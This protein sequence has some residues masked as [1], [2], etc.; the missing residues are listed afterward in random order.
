MVDKLTALV[1]KPEEAQ[2]NTR[3]ENPVIAKKA[4]NDL[5]KIKELQELKAEWAQALDLGGIKESGVP[6]G[7]TPEETQ[8]EVAAKNKNTGPVKAKVRKVQ[9]KEP[10]E[11]SPPTPEALEQKAPLPLN[12][13]EAT[14]P[15]PTYV[16]KHEQKTP[17]ATNKKSSAP[18]ESL[19][20]VQ[21]G[22]YKTKA[23]AEILLRKLIKKGY[24]AFMTHNKVYRIQ[25]EKFKNK[26]DALNLAQGIQEKEKL[27]NFVTT[28]QPG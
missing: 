20:T 26:E 27:K 14:L 23:Y 7:K 22:A 13:L 28:F 17:L 24:N 8:V 11:A 10:E 5:R 18:A 12:A 2:E 21:V 3:F 6:A 25:V 19:Y 1:K 16:E 4:T 15:V 9:A